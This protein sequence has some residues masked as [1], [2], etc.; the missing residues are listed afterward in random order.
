MQEGLQEHDNRSVERMK[1]EALKPQ[2]TR[3]EI[4]QTMLE[5]N[6]RWKPFVPE[7]PKQRRRRRI[8]R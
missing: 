1:R 6:P 2:R 5:L 3:E 7:P 8:T 4:E